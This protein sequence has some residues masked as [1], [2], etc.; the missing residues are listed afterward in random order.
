MSNRCSNLCNSRSFS[1]YTPFLAPLKPYATTRRPFFPFPHSFILIGRRWRRGS[2]SV[3]L[4]VAAQSSS[5]VVLIATKV[6]SD[7]SLVFRF[8]D[9]S[10]VVENDDVEEEI[11]SQT[12]LESSVVK[13]LDGDQDR[14]VI[15][16]TGD[17]GYDSVEGRLVEVADEIR[18]ADIESDIDESVTYDITD[19]EDNNA[20]SIVESTL[21]EARLSVQLDEEESSDTILDLLDDTP[22]IEKRADPEG[23]FLNG[24]DDN[25]VDPSVSI[26]LESTHVSENEVMDD[27]DN[28]EAE[29]TSKSDTE[30][31]SVELECT[32]VLP[33]EL[34]DDLDKVEA[35][36]TSK[37][38]TEDVSVE[39]ESTQVLQTELMDDLDKVEAE[40]TS[41]S[42][43][44][45]VSVELESTQ[46]LQTELMDDLDNVEAE[47]TSKSDTEDV[48]VELESTQVLQTELMDDLDKVETED[49]RKSDTEEIKPS[50]N[51]GT[52]EE[53]KDI[54]IDEGTMIDEVSPSKSL[55][56]QLTGAVNED[57]E[58]ELQDMNL[59]EAT[60]IDEIPSSDQLAVELTLDE[61]NQIQS[62]KDQTTEDELQEVSTENREENDVA[63]VVPVSA[64]EEAEIIVE[65]EVSQPQST[66]LELK[67]AI[68]VLDPDLQDTIGQDLDNGILQDDNGIKVPSDS[69]KLEATQVSDNEVTDVTQ[70]YGEDESQVADNDTNDL[71]RPAT[72]HVSDVDIDEKSQDTNISEGTFIDEMPTPAPL[73]SEPTL[74]VLTNKGMN[75]DMDERLQ[76]MTISEGTL[77]D[78][79]PTSNLLGAEPTLE[80][81]ATK[82]MDLK[83][84]DTDE[85]LQYKNVRE[86]TLIDETPTFDPLGAEPTLEAS[87]TKD[88]NVNDVNTDQTLQDMNIS[89]GTFIDELPT[90]D[91]LGSEPTLAVSTTKGMDV[92]DVDMDEKLQDMNISEG[93]FI[94]EMPTP[95]PLESEP[96]LEVSTNKGMNIDLDERLQDMNISE[97]P[98]IHEIPASDPLGA[99]PTLEVSSNEGMDIKDPTV[100]DELQLVSNDVDMDERLQDMNISE[101][102]FT[103]EIPAS[104]PL[105]AEPTLE[106]SSDEGMDIKDLAVED[107]VQLVSNDN[108][109]EN[110]IADVL[111]A[112]AILEEEVFQPHLKPIELEATMPVSDIEAQDAKGQNLDDEILPVINEDAEQLSHQLESEPVQDEGVKRLQDM[113]ISEDKFIGEIPTS[114]PLGTESMLEGSTTEDKDVKDL[115]VEDELQLVSNDKTEENEIADVMPAEPILEEEV[116]QPQLTPVELKDTM[117]VSDIKVQD[118]TGQNLDDEISQVM[119]EDAGD[120]YIE[121]VEPSPHELESLLVQDEGVKDNMLAQ[122][123]ESDA[124]ESSILL[125]KD[126]HD[127]LPEAERTED[128]VDSSELAE[129]SEVTAFLLAAEAEVEREEI[130][131]TD[132]FLLSGAA[133]LEHPSKALTGGDDAYFVAGSKWLGV[134][135]GV[136]QWS[137]EGTG[138]GV[139]AQELMRT[140]EEIVLDTCNVPV[141]NPV[142]LLCRGVKETNM[143]GS[144]NV[145]LANFNGQVLHVANIGDTGFLVIRH[146][147]IYKKSSPSLHEF[148]FALQ[149]EDSDDPLQLVEESLIE[150]EV[151]DIVISATDGLFDNLYEREITMIVSK[152]LQAGMKPKEIANILATRAQEVGK[153]SFVRSPFSDAAQAAGYTGYAGGKP[154][155]VAVIVSL[156]EKGS[157]LLAV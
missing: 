30:D 132:D 43:T 139:Y 25:T 140:C 50:A 107:E 75:V 13:V 111:P 14:Q 101:G 135:S 84:I 46:V 156:V 54:I 91:P 67:P 63:Y 129:V 49:S 11:E 114:D 144:S 47:D 125:I 92:S 126:A 35:E 37:S 99:E 23:T 70:P 42:V 48:S 154:D 85:R 12:E 121:D 52:D 100:E 128:V 34:I 105:G 130:Y 93:T 119:N 110:E 131:L 65:E 147:A 5:D 82:D 94:D 17:S 81:A 80:I 8:G 64:V 79:I 26:E 150:L 137:F 109:G 59:N 120:G 151:G 20:E 90:S 68:Q 115:A 19:L 71:L 36:D 9:A 4:K 15:I 146:G 53:L 41:K 123:D 60:I 96:S 10:E 33:T 22:D 127:L 1:L 89:E 108:M 134:A 29:D 133:L 142:E 73:G 95:D 40:D 145:L 136:S 116:S 56:V 55:D 122:R 138:P 113:N 74:E 18:N 83:D 97:G 45:D 16:E 57:V 61:V 112:E 86:D 103:D 2:S 155:N 149:V 148:H 124:V 27:L 106:V 32:Q 69:V 3:R 141:T 143:S 153:S 7:G 78:E 157:N 77:I 104:D 28:V 31:V 102:T 24:T 118:A 76:D 58:E 21:D 38:V 152:S 66:P 117:Q 62:V 6:H 39:L 72:M 51:E 98:F 88:K 44:E 87:T